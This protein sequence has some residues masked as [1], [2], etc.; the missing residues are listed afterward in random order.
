MQSCRLAEFATTINGLLQRRSGP[1]ETGTTAAISDALTST[2]CHIQGNLNNI[3]RAVNKRPRSKI[4][5]QVK[6]AASSLTPLR[7]LDSGGY[8]KRT[9][10]A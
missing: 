3:E 10:S 5:K 9:E 2:K 4:S 8:V 7:F 6:S 1:D